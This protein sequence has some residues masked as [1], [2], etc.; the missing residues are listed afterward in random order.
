M[1]NT[2][3]DLRKV[4]GQTEAMVP[5]NLTKS[6]KRLPVIYFTIIVLLLI[7]AAG[8]TAA[9]VAT[10]HTLSLK[11]TALDAA[12]NTIQ[13]KSNELSN[14]QSNLQNAQSDAS[15]AHAQANQNAAALSAS[16]AQLSAS[17]SQLNSVNIRL[18]AA[19]ACISLFNST[20]SSIQIYNSDMTTS[21]ADMA[22]SALDANSGDYV[23]ASYLV[24]QAQGQFD[25]AT[26]IFGGIKNTMAK[27]S[28]GSC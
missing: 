9:L 3:F 19:Q 1:K 21:L 6:I 4:E 18:S 24:S 2:V 13:S 22:Q 14:T 10:T 17:E 16:Q 20:S 25:T 12:D 7:G 5:R 8:L 27:V 28:T 26:N 23:T 15:A 11:E